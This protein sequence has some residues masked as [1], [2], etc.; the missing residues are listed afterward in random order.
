MNVDILVPCK[1]L[2]VSLNQ[3]PTQIEPDKFQSKPEHFREKKEKYS[4]YW[5]PV[6][7]YCIFGLW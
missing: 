6:Q 3:N 2:K 7:A 5:F 4:K 1:V